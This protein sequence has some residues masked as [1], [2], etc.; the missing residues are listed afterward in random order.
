MSFNNLGNVNR[1][2]LGNF[3]KQQYRKKNMKNCFA[4]F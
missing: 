3:L 4:Y 1:P 2:Y